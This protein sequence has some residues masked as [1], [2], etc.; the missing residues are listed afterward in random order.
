MATAIKSFWELISRK[1]KF[2]FIALLIFVFLVSVYEIFTICVIAIF[3]SKLSGDPPPNLIQSFIFFDLQRT[4]SNL[5]IIVIAAI[6]FKNISQGLLFYFGRYFAAK[7][8]GYIS[9]KLFKHFINLPFIWHQRQSSSELTLAVEWKMHLGNF[10]DYL[11]R[12]FREFLMVF[13]ILMLMTII[14]LWE[15]VIF[16]CIIGAAGLIIH[17]ILTPKI[18]TYAEKCKSLNKSMH[19]LTST[20]LQGIKEIKV[21][22]AGGYF[23]KSYDDE[24][25]IFAHQIATRETLARLTMLLLELLGF[26]CLISFYL[27]RETNQNNNYLFSELALVAVATLRI[28]PAMTIVAH[29]FSS[30]KVGLPFVSSMFSFLKLKSDEDHFA[31]REGEISFNKD[32]YMDNV[33][34][35]YDDSKTFKLKNI[36]LTIPKGKMVGISGQSGSGKTTLV[37]LI[38]GLLKPESG[39]IKIDGSI[40]KENNAQAWQKKIGY[41]P[42]HPYLIKGPL[43]SN[44]TFGLEEKEA[45]ED[46][47]IECCNLA[48]MKDIL[49]GATQGIHTEVGERGALFSGGQMQRIA[50]ARALYRKP[51]VLILDEATSALDKENEQRW[52]ECLNNLR[53]RMTVILISHKPN[54]LENC[55]SVIYLQDGEIINKSLPGPEKSSPQI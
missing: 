6:V 23:A 44:I 25:S 45:D 15:G 37:D 33:S 19:N 32:I 35:E 39:S 50:I 48:S 40:L 43:S 51:D 2:Q 53:E 38:I 11:F 12:I 8:S 27:Y 47:I 18:N 28:L 52:Q 31:V 13:F 9:V 16:F 24:T 42:Q 46:W 26:L 5:G 41:V 34:F 30:V 14:G 21:F 29:S 7:A 55:D 3:A 17:K 20:V 10:V 1:L 54:T 49:E 22:D 36:N 4:A